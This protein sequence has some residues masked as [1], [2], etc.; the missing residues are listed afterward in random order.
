MS[1]AGQMIG[2]L[3]LAAEHG[4]EHGAE[5]AEGFDVMGYAFALFNFALCIGTIVY[6]AGPKVTVFLKDRRESLAKQLNEARQK[7]A[8]ADKRLAE[9]GHKLDHLE[10]EV[11]RII[12]SFEA[13]GEAD[14]ERFKTDTDKAIERLVREVDF[15][16]TQESLKAQRAIRAAAVESTL[17]M[18]EKMVT[19]RITEADKRR[20]ADEYVGQLDRTEKPN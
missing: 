16:I 10:D 17:S 18:A 8:E 20:L 13:Q 9:Y 11:G 2:M 6:F 12:K 5:H 19:E 15:T 3:M 14:R 7:Q 4:A 1:I